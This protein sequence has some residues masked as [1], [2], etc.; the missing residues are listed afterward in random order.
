[1]P[2]AYLRTLH[3]CTFYTSE[4]EMLFLKSNAGLLKITGGFVYN[5]SSAT[6]KHHTL[7]STAQL[8]TQSAMGISATHV[9]RRYVGPCFVIMCF[10]LVLFVISVCIIDMIKA[11]PTSVVAV[12]TPCVGTQTE[13]RHQFM[14]VVEDVFVNSAF[15]D[16]R[17]NDVDAKDGTITRA[18]AVRIM[19]IMRLTV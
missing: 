15:L 12:S 8:P 14:E 10:S 3:I 17:D 6:R 16:E 18:H 19:A 13:D 2:G 7:E 4:I 11:K 9:C 5:L 1:M